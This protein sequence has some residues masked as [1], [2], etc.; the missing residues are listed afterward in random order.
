MPSVR[1]WDDQQQNEVCDT[2]QKALHYAQIPLLRCSGPWFRGIATLVDVNL[3]IIHT[4]CTN[5]QIWQENVTS[6]EIVNCIGQQTL[7]NTVDVG[8]WCKVRLEFWR[9]IVARDGMRDSKMVLFSF[10]RNL[11][12]RA[13]KEIQSDYLFCFYIPLPFLL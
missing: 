2:E 10:F 7:P 13:M 5:S 11:E 4:A 3:Q 8:T 1:F 12:F 9:S 6:M